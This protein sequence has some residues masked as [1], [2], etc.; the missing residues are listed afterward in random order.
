M[1]TTVRKGIALFAVAF[2]VSGCTKAVPA[3]ANIIDVNASL[4]KGNEV[5]GQY[6][7][8]ALTL[9]DLIEKY[10]SAVFVNAE[11]S[12]VTG[13]EDLPYSAGESEYFIGP[14]RIS[15]YSWLK[16]LRHGTKEILQYPAVQPEIEIKLASDQTVAVYILPLAYLDDETNQ[17]AVIKDDHG[18]A[19]GLWAVI[20][21]S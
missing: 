4:A 15:A 2:L 21:E 14:V 10:P 18:Y 17:Y 16:S 20:P 6:P 1:K 3:D 11:G 9:N 13:E 7:V 19:K 5:N 12:I 8:E